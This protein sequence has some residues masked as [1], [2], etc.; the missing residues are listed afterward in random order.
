MNPSTPRLSH[1]QLT[2][3]EIIDAVDVLG[4]GVFSDPITN[5]NDPTVEQL[6]SGTYLNPNGLNTV[7]FLKAIHDYY[8]KPIYY[9]DR[10]FHSFDGSNINHQQIFDQNPLT[11]DNKEQADLYE[12]FFRVW[13][14]EQGSWM[15]G[16]SFNNANRIPDG[17][18]IV[19]RFLDSPFGENFQGK[20]AEAVIRDWF[21]GN[22]QGA[23]L[24][25][26]GTAAADRLEGGYNHDVISGAS[27][28]DTLFGGQGRDR[29]AGG[30]GDDVFDGG[31]DVDT[32]IFSGPRTGYTIQRSGNSLIVTHT[33]GGTD[34]RDILTSVERL[35]FANGTLAFDVDGSAGQAYR[36]Y[37]AAFDRT[38]DQGGLSFWIGRMDQGTSLVD[39]ARGFLASAEAQSIYGANS[40]NSSF[41]GLLYQHVLHRPGEAAGVNFW[42]GQLDSG[43][44]SRAEVLAGFSESPENVTLVG[45]SI[46]NGIL[47]DSLA[48]M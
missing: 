48:F 5:L 47:I 4:V 13:S 2:P 30:P 37:Q 41:V 27:G 22:R 17:L 19:A 18:Q 15:R 43:V 7:S 29:L 11:I 12:S 46:Q 40:T 42:T 38:P 35:Q 8:N 44:R 34:G 9:S 10:T 16:V 6:V 45:S 23:G 20:P 24:Q 28:N 36:I 33:D 25:M 32:A 14:N 21:S 3:H 31:K 39:V 1:F 26:V